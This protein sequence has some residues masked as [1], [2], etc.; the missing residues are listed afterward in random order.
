MLHKPKLLRI[1]Q[2]RIKEVIGPIFDVK[3]EF[4]K[5]ALENKLSVRKFKEYIDKECPSENIKLV[6]YFLRLANCVYS[7]RRSSI[8]TFGKRR[9][10][11]SQPEKLVDD[12]TEVLNKL[13][14]VL[15]EMKKDEVLLADSTPTGPNPAELNSSV[16]RQESEK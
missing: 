7:E 8:M 6:F 1:Q 9:R 11:K 2:D 16:S 4:A 3:K 14:S 10:K 12:Y 5:Y 13:K 15:S